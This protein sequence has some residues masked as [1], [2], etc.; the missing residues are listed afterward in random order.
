MVLGKLAITGSTGMVGSHLRRL[1]DRKNVPHMGVSRLV[2]VDSSPNLKRWDLAEWKEP[3]QLD[4]IFPE[5]SAVIHLAAILPQKKE[6]RRTMFDVNVRSCLCLGQWAMEKDIPL[7]YISSAAV[8]KNPD[9][10]GTNEDDPTT[11][12]GLGGF[13][14]CTKLMGEKILNHLAE[15]GLKLCILRPSSIYGFG[16][17]EDK[18]IPRFLAA[19]SKDET[20]DLSPPTGD[21]VNLIHASDVARAI[22]AALKSQATGTFNIAG[23]ENPSF[24]DIAQAC[25]DVAG[26]GRVNAPET[27]KEPGRTRFDLD[28]SR[29]KKAFAFSAE[30]DLHSGLEAMLGEMRKQGQAQ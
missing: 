2:G 1:L 11:A 17:P 27:D 7:V 15:N 5:A 26:K 20:I 30:T 28:C 24:L 18:A 16:L 29:A 25:V 22:V 19:A 4:S 6:D 3:D 13:Y 8:Y 23:P 12:N 10:S 21:R 14:C 9:K